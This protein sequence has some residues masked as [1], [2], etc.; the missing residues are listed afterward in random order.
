MH[1]SIIKS[2]QNGRVY[3]SKLLRESY[4]DE[5]GRVQKR[6]LA[7]LSALPDD[8]IEALRAHLR[9]DSPAPVPKGEPVEIIDSRYHGGVLAVRTAFEELGFDT[10]ISSTPSGE[11][12]IICALVAARILRQDS[13]LP[14]T[15][16]WNTVTLGDV[17]GIE[18]V[19][20][21]AVHSAMDLLLKRRN[22]IQGKLARRH[23]A[24]SAPVLWNLIS[25]RF[26]G[27][28]GSLAKRGKSKINF[29]LL[30]DIRGCPVAV[31]VNADN[32]SDNASV[33]NE[34]RRWQRKLK[35]GHVTVIGDRGTM[36]RPAIDALSCAEGVEWISGLKRASVRSLL[37]DGTLEPL[38]GTTAPRE[39]LHPDY[40]DE[41][42]IACR[43]P[44]L[45]RREER[46]RNELLEA[47]E[48]ELEMLRQRVAD[49]DLHGAGNIGIAAGQ[50]I[51]RFKVAKR[52]KID[53]TDTTL[54]IHRRTDRIEEE[55][56]LDG[57]QVI[58]TTLSQT[59][60]AAADCLR[61]FANLATVKR[62][63]RFDQADDLQLLPID[64][65]S[66]DLIRAHAVVCMLAHHVEWH[67][68]AAWAPLL[69]AAPDFETVQEPPRPS[70]PEQPSQPVTSAT[71]DSGQ[72]DTG[73][74]DR[75]F[76][77]ILASLSTVTRNLCRHQGSGDA[78]A[79]SVTTT[80][81]AEQQ[82]A[83]DRLKS[84]SKL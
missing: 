47:A 31:S 69:G 49:G 50:V 8:A 24:D 68:R 20:A 79:F 75:S 51:D 21:D 36:A 52:L 34:L 54:E 67:M 7:N 33:V 4:R 73:I 35:F 17:F 63:F 60:M 18:D 32:P 71:G 13:E 15:R 19:D 26:V 9:G 27:D 40:P 48:N 44:A 57:I 6:T 76:R 55:A 72:T 78:K 74:P 39:I 16:W 28:R 62:A 77:T 37:G 84:I 80:P 61:N 81:N 64:R 25:T 2:V 83:F 42:L 46:R 38:K 82:D 14:T 59:E 43:H 41:R 23:L 12:D 5:K 56:A 29:G 58:R 3:Y 10:L 22:R 70:T 11:R 45:A 53:I 1:I 66:P 30:C 65:S